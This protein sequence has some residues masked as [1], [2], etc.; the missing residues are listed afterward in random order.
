LGNS[1]PAKWEECDAYWLWG[2]HNILILIS[3]ISPV[4]RIALAFFLYSCFQTKLKFWLC[5]LFF[6]FF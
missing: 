2:C 3:A 6:F 5:F 4:S 1:F